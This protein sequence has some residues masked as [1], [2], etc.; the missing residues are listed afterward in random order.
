[1]LQILDPIFVLRSGFPPKKTQASGFH[2]FPANIV[3][4]LSLLRQVHGDTQASRCA[5]R[6]PEIQ[7]GAFGV[8]E[9]CLTKA[10]C[11]HKGIAAHN[12]GRT[13]GIFCSRKILCLSRSVFWK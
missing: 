11:T 9:S 6:N 12:S 2:A 8:S 10:N 5:H 1:M 3:P 13:M 7:A 4:A